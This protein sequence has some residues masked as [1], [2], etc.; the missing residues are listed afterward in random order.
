MHGSTTKE[1]TIG[2]LLDA[3]LSVEAVGVYKPHPKVY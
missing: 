1:T 3:I 2:P